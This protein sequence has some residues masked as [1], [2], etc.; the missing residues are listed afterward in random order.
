MKN[1]LEIADK[2]ARLADFIIDSLLFILLFSFLFIFL[3][4]LFPVV[5][6]EKIL[7]IERLIYLLYFLYYFLF[8]FLLGKTPGQ[9]LTKSYVVDYEGNKPGVRAILIRSA[10]RLLI[11]FDIFSYVFGLVG[12][13]DLMSKTTVVWKSRNVFTGTY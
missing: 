5:L 7:I 4:I 6:E 3:S 8:E 1:R 12:L 13:H 9:Y 2:G 10:L 11:P